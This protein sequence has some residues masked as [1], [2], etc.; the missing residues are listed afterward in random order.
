MGHRNKSHECTMMCIVFNTLT[1][2]NN[3]IELFST[4][5]VCILHGS[6]MFLSRNVDGRVGTHNGAH[7]VRW[8]RTWVLSSNCHSSYQGSFLVSVHQCMPLKII[9]QRQSEDIHK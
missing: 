6:C 4:Y 9:N 3:F 7:T 5:V 1:K 2:Q 8:G